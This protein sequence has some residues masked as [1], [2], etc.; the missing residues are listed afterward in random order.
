VKPPGLI[1]GQA[2]EGRAPLGP[3][4]LA[5][6]ECMQLYA[7]PESPSTAWVSSVLPSVCDHGLSR[8]KISRC[9]TERCGLVG[10]TGD[11]WVVRLDGLKR[12][13]PSL[14]VLWFYDR[15]PFSL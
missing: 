12:S 10:N 11:R 1:H 2:T 14:V 4:L 3:G 8:Q 5:G 9:C 15:W 7:Q 13:F 6:E